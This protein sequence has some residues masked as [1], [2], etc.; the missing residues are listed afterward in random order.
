M[1]EEQQSQGLI[2]A[3]RELAEAS[4]DQ[5]ENTDPDEYARFIRGQWGGDCE[6]GD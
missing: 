3:F 5:W 1:P 4:G 6:D 2:E